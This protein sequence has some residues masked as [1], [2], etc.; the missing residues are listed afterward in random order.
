M[1]V[2]AKDLIKQ[3]THRHFIS[4]STKQKQQQQQ[5]CLTCLLSLTIWRLLFRTPLPCRFDLPV[6][7]STHIYVNSF[8]NIICNKNW[9]KDF[10]SRWQHTNFLN[11][12]LLNKLQPPSKT[13]LLD[14]GGTD[15]KQAMSLHSEF[16]IWEQKLHS[17]RGLWRAYIYS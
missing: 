6:L 1:A 8:K 5:I 2:I 16:F 11:S 12:K 10:Q 17:T 4:P 15:H 14:P 7:L 9:T 13:A 3:K